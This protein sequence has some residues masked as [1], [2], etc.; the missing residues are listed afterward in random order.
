MQEYP[1]LE[2]QVVGSVSPVNLN[3]SGAFKHI[4]SLWVLSEPIKWIHIM[5]IVIGETIG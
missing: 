5:K 2:W 1:R 3:S 4:V